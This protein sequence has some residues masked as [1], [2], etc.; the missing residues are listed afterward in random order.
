L[1]D[2][3]AEIADGVRA[4]TTPGHTPGHQSVMVDTMTGR[5][6][7]A[8]DAVMWHEN[9]ERRISPGVHTSIVECMA[10]LERIAREAD[11]MHPGHEPLLFDQRPVRLPT[12]PD[13]R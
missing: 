8:G 12:V 11:H 4:I 10:F 6:C 7:I 9:L 3:D 1:L 13:T 2:G 5:Y